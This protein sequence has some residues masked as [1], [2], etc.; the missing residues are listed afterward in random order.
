MV[1]ATLCFV[2][3]ACMITFSHA[4][5]PGRNPLSTPRH[6]KHTVMHESV[7]PLAS[8]LCAYGVVPSVL[9][10]N[11]PK[12]KGA[13]EMDMDY[14]FENLLNRNKGNEK[15]NRGPRPLYK[16]PR[17]MDSAFGTTTLDIVKQTIHGFDSTISVEEIS[18]QAEQRYHG[19]LPYFKTFVPIV[20]SNT[21]DQYYVDI[22]LYIY[23]KI[24]SERIKTS[25]ERVQFR[26]AVGESIYKSILSEL[27]QSSPVQS[28]A[29]DI[30]T[31]SNGIEAL[32]TYFS[33]K[34]FIANFV[35]DKEDLNDETYAKQTFAQNLPV[36]TQITLTEP[37]T[38][39]GFLQGYMEDTFFH[40]EIVATTVAAYLRAHGLYSKYEDYLLDEYYRE[41]NFDLQ[42]QD[43]VVEIEFV[44]SDKTPKSFRAFN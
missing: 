38:L 13:F 44:P 11:A 35:Y 23:Y 34:R 14:Y 17:R 20:K 29:Q 8:L 43:V 39:I 30:G 16:S 21:E 1:S 6:L 19:K 42:A 9:A 7:L 41:S 5:T 22:M 12:P 31:I 33:Q 28:S 27:P 32:L 40:P 24:A 15:D 10:A 37:C 18:S 4:C 25:E 3:W 2:V 36:S 26:K